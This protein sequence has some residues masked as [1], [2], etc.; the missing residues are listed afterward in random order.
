LTCGILVQG[1]PLALRR[2]KAPARDAGCHVVHVG[3]ADTRSDTLRSAG[4]LVVTDGAA[5]AGI[6]HFVVR[7]NRVRFTVDDDA[8]AQSG[9]AISSKLLNVAVSVKPRGAR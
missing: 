8:A 4:T 1:H 2:L 9:L 5:S 3:A 6:I 7:D